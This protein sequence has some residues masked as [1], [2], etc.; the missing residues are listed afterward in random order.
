MIESPGHLAKG[1][2]GMPLADALRAPTL[3]LFTKRT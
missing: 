3:C 2:N 1:C